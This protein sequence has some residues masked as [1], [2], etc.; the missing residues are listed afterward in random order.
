MAGTGWKKENSA[1]GV[2]Y[3][4]EDSAFFILLINP[5]E[6]NFGPPRDYWSFPKGHIDEGENKEQAAVREVRE[7]AGIN[8]KIIEKLGTEKYFVNASYGKFL[9]FVDYYLMEYIDGDTEDHDKEVAEARWVEIGEAEK[10]LKF[11]HDKEV[12]NRAKKKL[13]NNKQ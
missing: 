2:V 11:E 3:K 8:A 5:R 7:E 9:K 10:M 6:P 4:K 1:G 13:V 12:F